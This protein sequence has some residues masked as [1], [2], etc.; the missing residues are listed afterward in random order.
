M[1]LEE[2]CFEMAVIIT[3]VERENNPN[4]DYGKLLT[5]NYYDLL[6]ALTIYEKEHKRLE[7]YHSL[8]RGLE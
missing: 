6:D 1:A 3:D 7:D 8:Q 2:D 5:S 4:L